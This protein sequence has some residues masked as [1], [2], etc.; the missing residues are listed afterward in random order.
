MENA[1]QMRGI[2]EESWKALLIMMAMDVFVFGPRRWFE[3][4][5]ASPPQRSPC[6]YTRVFAPC[7]C[8]EAFGPQFNFSVRERGGDASNASS[9]VAFF[10]FSSRFFQTS[11][12]T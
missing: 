2:L 12:R 5:G 9:G 1:A 10:P 6:F 4:H 3:E 8:A 11:F 7:F